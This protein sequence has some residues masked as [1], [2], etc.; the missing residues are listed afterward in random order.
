[1]QAVPRSLHPGGPQ[2]VVVLV[3]APAPSHI[4]ADVS[5]WPT[6]DW[7]GPHDVPAAVGAPSMHVFTPPVHE[8]TPSLQAPG[9]V[10]HALPAAQAMQF[11]AVLQTMSVPQLLPGV[12]LPAST[13]VVAPVAQDVVP[14]LHALGFPEQALPAVHDP[15]IPDPLQTMFGPQLVPAALLPP[16]R[17]VITPV[18]QDV[19][20]FLQ[21]FGLAEQLLLA[22][23][24]P[25]IPDPLQTMFAPQLVPAALLPASMH[26]IAPVEQDVIPFLQ[27]AF[28]FVVQP[29]PAVHVPHAPEPLQTMFV[30]QLVPA[31]LLLPSTHV[32]APVEQD[33]VPFL[34]AAFGFVAQELP[35]VHATQV[36]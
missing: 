21:G 15:H 12:L 30:P 1:M 14:S 3:Q 19:V 9:L 13:Q 17:H 20:P 22:V 31:A 2:S 23:Q 27:A 32:I 10:L 29:L 28:G 5:V 18:A 11:P 26:V 25:H 4:A 7:T 34:H 33:V 8:M 24:A 35:A 36:P 6:H 16:S